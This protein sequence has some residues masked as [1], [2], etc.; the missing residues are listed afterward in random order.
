[1]CMTSCEDLVSNKCPR[2][3][4]KG[5]LVSRWFHY[6]FKHY[7]NGKVTWCYVPRD[8]AKGLLD[9]RVL[10]AKKGENVTTA[11]SRK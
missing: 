3:G 1:V 6:Y 4:R 5:W 2:C 7:N 8:V 9:A 10:D 11:V